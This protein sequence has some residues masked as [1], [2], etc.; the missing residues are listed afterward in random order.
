MALYNLIIAVCWGVFILYWII[1]AFGVKRDINRGPWWHFWLLRFFIAFAILTW[2]WSRS[3]LGHVMQYLPLFNSTQN[4]IPLAILGTAFTVL[5]IGLAIW[6]RVHLGRNWSPAPAMKEAH[7][8]VTS[9]PYRLV[10]HPI[11]T[12]IMLAALGSALVTPTWLFMF[13]IISGVFIWRVKTEE[14][15]MMQ[16]FPTQYP[17]YKK[18]TWALIP[19]IW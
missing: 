10:R 4:N 16:L 2:A 1:S 15:F 12:G 7:E 13:V 5:G 14:G 19:Y 11:Y 3:S 18:R 8:L 9:G 6:A 17:D